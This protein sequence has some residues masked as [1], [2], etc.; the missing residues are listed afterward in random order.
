LISDRELCSIR[1]RWIE[2]VAGKAGRIMTRNAPEIIEVTSERF[3]EL[4]QRADSNT[5]REEDMELMRHVFASYAG[6]F[7]IVGDKKTTIA[8][9]RK[10]MFGATSEKSKNVLGDGDDIPNPSGGDDADD[11][12]SEFESS[13]DD[14]SSA[15][16][17]GHGRYAAEDYPGADQVHVS[18][19][20]LSPGDAC[21]DCG[22]G[23]LYEKSPGVLVA[24]LARHPCRQPS[25]AGRSCGA[26]CAENCSRHRFPP[27]LVTTSTT[28]RLPV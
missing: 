2:R 11:A 9:L 28:I 20:E 8:R 16:P 27:A 3:E 4:L 24:L 15:P 25:I 18:H 17:P 22:Q 14:G 19:P 1:V 6:F 13:E 12:S 23:K 7:Q 5:L 21:P 10:L 26:I